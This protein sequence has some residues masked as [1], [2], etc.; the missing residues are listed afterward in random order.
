MRFVDRKAVAE[1]EILQAPFTRGRKKGR[2]ELDDVTDF[3]ARKAAGEATGSYT[4]LRYKEDAVTEALEALPR[5]EL[6]SVA[7]CSICWPATELS[8][9]PAHDDGPRDLLLSRAR[10]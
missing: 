4:F 2:S 10:R 3:M 5:T 9:D 6:N 8:I 7:P 1:P